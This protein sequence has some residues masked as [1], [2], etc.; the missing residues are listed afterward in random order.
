MITM[1]SSE[2]LVRAAALYL[3]I[4]G[5]L[6]LV[7]LRPPS[8][9]RVAGAL[10]ATVWNLVALLAVNLVAA[11]LGWW[12]FQAEAAT[13]AGIPADLWLGWALLWGAV[14]LLATT[15]RLPL[16]VLGLVAADLVLMP[17]AQ[18]VV[19]L[20]RLWLVGEVLAVVAA[21]VPGL[22]L[23]RWTARAEHLGGR[24]ALQVAAFTGLVFFVL[25]AVIFEIAG[26]GWAP[27]LG[28]S[29]GQ[30]VLAAVVLAPVGA[31]ALQAVREFAA[32]GGTPLP[33]DPPRAL[34]STGPYAY[35]ANP[36]QLS[37]SILLAAWG[38][39]LASPAVVAASAMG[40]VFSAGIAGW[41]EHRE[42]C[43]RFGPSWPEYRA[44][45]RLWLPRWRPAAGERATVYVARTCEPCSEVGGFL[46]RRHGVGV[47]VRPAEGSPVPLERVTYQRTGRTATGVAAILH[48][49]EHVHLGWAVLSWIGRLPLVSALVQ[50]IA[51][52]VGGE[53]RALAPSPTATRPEEQSWPAS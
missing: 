51:D 47:E 46:A 8:R 15:S 45:V 9:R 17:L 16:V 27:L 29:R 25:P 18:P 2:A 22:L 24:V 35:V 10:L 19:L 50:L 33:L 4:A 41:S 14:P 37:A 34:V 11:R 21:L 32:H 36:M 20:D 7:V 48:T 43:A 26:G 53:P 13:V 5:I 30:L 12:S 6:V 38:V 23:G 3:P 28:R 1:Q 40:I 49:L 52:A 42:L 31:T 39:V 44:D